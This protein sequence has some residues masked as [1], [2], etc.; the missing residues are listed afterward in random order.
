LPEIDQRFRELD[1][2]IRLR[3]EQHSALSKRLQ[4]MLTAPRPEHL[5]TSE[6]QQMAAQLERLEADLG[7]ADALLAERIDRLQGVLTW[8]LKT[9]YH[10]RLSQFY[11]HLQELGEA[12]DV[13]TE[14][15]EAYVRVRQAAVHSF[16]GYDV[17]MRQLRTRVGQALTNVGILMARQ[18]HALELVAINELMARRDRL[19]DYRNQARYALADSYDRATEMQITQVQE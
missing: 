14:E 2:R 16:E 5:A 6:E 13:M 15:Y 19:D 9:E 1:S 18:G 3:K 7:G 8:R 4:A 11:T 17:S 12:I 10:D